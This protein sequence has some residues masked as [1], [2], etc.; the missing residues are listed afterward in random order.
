MRARCGVQVEVIS[1]DEESRLGYLAATAGGRADGTRSVVVVETG[2]GSTQFTFG[3]GR[4]RRA[5]GSASRWARSGSRSATG[6]PGRRG[7]RPGARRL[8]DAAADLRRLTAE[9]APDALVGIGGAVHEPHGR[10]ARPGAY[11]P[12][13][14]E[15]TVLD[16]AEIDRQIERYRTS[17]ADER[18]TIVGLQ[19]E[20]AEVILAG[21]M[22]VRTMIDKLMRDSMTVSDRG[23]RHALVAE[24]FEGRGGTGG[25]GLKRIPGVPRRR[26][27][28]IA[29]CPRDRSATRTRSGSARRSRGVRW[30]GWRHPSR[31]SR[32]G[33]ERLAGDT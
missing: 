29:G 5:S 32:A 3:E 2:G 27:S 25:G 13:V 18:R 15:G 16:R 12:E 14:V 26:R 6:S 28:T 31:G 30:S 22:I 9:P 21:A 11:D 23:L 1:G 8:A 7:G 10:Q 4:P 24:R 19:P 20:R 33:A 17:G